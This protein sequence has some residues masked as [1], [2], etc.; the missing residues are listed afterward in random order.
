ME[1]AKNLQV[2]K[3][4][5]DATYEGDLMAWPGFPMPWAGKSNEEYGKP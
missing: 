1:V 4:F 2:E 5:L 3:V